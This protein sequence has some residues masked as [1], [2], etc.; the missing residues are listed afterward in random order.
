MVRTLLKKLKKKLE[1]P[2]LDDPF[3][4]FM[5]V[6]REEPEIK[7]TLVGILRQDDFHRTSILNTTIDEM[8]YQGAPETLI[9]SFACLLDKDLAARAY[10]LLTDSETD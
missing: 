10:R 2:Q 3:I 7:Q 4:T 1:N 8:R 9:R 5:Q 6:A